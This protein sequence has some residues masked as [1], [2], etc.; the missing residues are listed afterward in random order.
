M[1][2]TSFRYCEDY[3]IEVTFQDGTKAINDIEPWLNDGI[4][5]ALRD[6]EFFHRAKIEN[7]TVTWPNGADFCPDAYYQEVTRN[8][9]K[10]RKTA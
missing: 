8:K 2:I 9:D 10:I 7:G 1:R 4:F 5:K 3:K 6:K